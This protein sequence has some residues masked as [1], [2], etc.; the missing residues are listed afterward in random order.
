MP[1]PSPA[2]T[3]GS[4][5]RQSVW[6]R[7]EQRGHVADSLISFEHVVHIVDNKLL[8]MVC[9]WPPA[10]RFSWSLVIRAMQ[11]LI[12]GEAV[13]AFATPGYFF[14]PPLGSLTRT[15]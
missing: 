7:V 8:A 13:V 14:Q 11:G 15:R 3:A 6:L 1:Q 12:V 10:L 9:R 2:E 5:V 4:E